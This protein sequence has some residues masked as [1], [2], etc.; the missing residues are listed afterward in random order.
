MQGKGLHTINDNLTMSHDLQMIMMSTLDICLDVAH[1]SHN[2]WVWKHSTADTAETIQ[3]VQKFGTKNPRWHHFRCV[4]KWNW[5]NFRW[6]LSEFN[7][8][9]ISTCKVE[10]QSCK[11]L[12]WKIKQFKKLSA[13]DSHHNYGFYVN[14][15]HQY[16]NIVTICRFNYENSSSDTF[17]NAGRYLSCIYSTL[18][19]I[20]GK[21]SSVIC[22]I[23]NR[24]KCYTYGSSL[25]NCWILWWIY[26]FIT[27]SQI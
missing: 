13:F 17:W 23:R 20:I 22:L 14:G 9:Q 2:Y 16:I 10:I 24:L 15:R 4:C 25:H 11:E 8:R 6:H 5:R 19:I 1:P 21:E 27:W 3:K 18:Q 12:L 7:Y 26:I